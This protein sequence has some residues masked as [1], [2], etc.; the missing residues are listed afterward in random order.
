M[1][2]LMDSKLNG[3]RVMSRYWFRVVVVAA[4]GGAWC[5]QEWWY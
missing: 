4:V 1:G 5:W 3:G 2:F